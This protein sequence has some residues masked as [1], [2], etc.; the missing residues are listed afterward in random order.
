MTQH[1][2]GSD[3]EPSDALSHKESGKEERGKAGIPRDM[4][5]Y[6]GL[7]RG[8]ERREAK[9][10]RKTSQVFSGTHAAVMAGP[11]MVRRLQ[12]TQLKAAMRSPRLGQSTSPRLHRRCNPSTLLLL[13]SSETIRQMPACNKL[14]P[15]THPSGA[16]MSQSLAACWVNLPG[17][18]GEERRNRSIKLSVNTD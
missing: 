12:R 6:A 8:L 2:L 10:R 11:W 9:R 5:V 15:Q 7:I 14:Q 1:A 16:A 13:I 4:L 17:I 3:G 18:G